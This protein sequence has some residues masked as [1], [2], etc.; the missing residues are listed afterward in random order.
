MHNI[1]SKLILILM[2]VM[3]G[4][5]L[6]GQNYSNLSNC[7]YFWRNQ[8]ILETPPPR[9]IPSGMTEESWEI[10]RQR[11]GKILQDC[12]RQ[13]E[14]ELYTTINSLHNS[15]RVVCDHTQPE[16]VK[17]AAKYAALD[18]FTSPEGR[19][20]AN[21]YGFF[22]TEAY[23]L[24]PDT[25]HIDT[26]LDHII[27]KF[28][29][30]TRVNICW[31]IPEADEQVDTFKVRAP[32]NL[33]KKDSSDTDKS[34]RG[35]SLEIPIRERMDVLPPD[36]L[37]LSDEICKKISAS[38]RLFDAYD[39]ENPVEDSLRYYWETTLTQ[40]SPNDDSKTCRAL[41]AENCIEGIPP[42]PDTTG[43][44]DCSLRPLPDSCIAVCDT[45]KFQD[46]CYH[47][48]KWWT[49]LVPGLGIKEFQREGKKKFPWPIITSVWAGSTIT[50]G[51][52]RIK[53]LRSYKAHKEASILKILDDKYEEAQDW[54]KIFLISGGL[55]ILT[56]LG[57]DLILF[58]KDHTNYK[59]CLRGFTK[60]P[61]PA[62]TGYKWAP[63]LYTNPLEL[64]VGLKFTIQPK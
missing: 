48:L 49:Y 20:A 58:D 56:G 18:L 46:S 36:G 21:Y 59:K 32:V 25:R 57:T 8:A 1:L 9:P 13:K 7:V 12:R 50:A 52:A 61:E 4:V 30:T 60:Q 35:Y 38:L 28:R 19:G 41:P 26:Y 43:G 27:E 39:P 5:Y 10:E 14:K 22:F 24:N 16:A 17:E 23:K 54:H 6:F 47:R 42:P 40:V 62:S 45:L 64:S 44:C 15:F 29:D 37:V 11:I 2:T 31:G 51:Y 33:T 63:Q 55:S 53:S 3:P 34:F